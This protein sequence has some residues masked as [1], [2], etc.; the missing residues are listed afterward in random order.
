VMAFNTD[1]V[2]EIIRGVIQNELNLINV[3]GYVLG[4]VVGA[5]TFVAA[6]AIGL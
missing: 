5:F 1:R 2:E 3:A 4:A 6:R